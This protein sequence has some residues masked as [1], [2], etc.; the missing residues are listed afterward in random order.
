MTGEAIF[1]VFESVIQHS[2]EDKS[3]K[4]FMKIHPFRIRS[5]KMMFMK[6]VKPSGKR[7]RR[8]RDAR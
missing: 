8:I 5:L 2:S 7:I 4:I 3:L 1:I 6:S